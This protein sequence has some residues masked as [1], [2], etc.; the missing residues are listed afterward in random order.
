MHHLC[1]AWVKGHPSLPTI[2][3]KT[4]GFWGQKGRFKI[5][6]VHFVGGGLDQT[7]FNLSVSFCTAGTAVG[8]S[9]APVRSTCGDACRAFC[10][11][12]GRC[13]FLRQG[14]DCSLPLSQHHPWK[15]CWTRGLCLKNFQDSY[16]IWGESEVKSGFRQTNVI[17]IALYTAVEFY[18]FNIYMCTYVA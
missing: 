2:L 16:E 18:L 5:L 6:F 8:F 7:T 15:R 10:V 14:S 17:Y 1:S 13:P 11:V 4:F 3:T 12:P 9:L